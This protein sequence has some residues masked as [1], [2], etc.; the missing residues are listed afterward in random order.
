[1]TYYHPQSQIPNLDKIYERYFTRFFE[2]YSGFFVEVG[3]YDGYSYS[4]TSGLA[5][6]GWK[7]IYIEPVFEYYKK[8]LMRHKDNSVKVINCAI[9]SIEEQTDLYVGDYLTTLDPKYVEIYGEIEWSKKIKFNKQRTNKVRLD[10][11][12]KKYKVKSNF[13]LLVVDVEGFEEDVFSSFSIEYWRPK[14]I[15][16]ELCDVHFS[17]QK[18]NYAITS[19]KNLRQK[20][21]SNNYKQI[22]VDHINTVFVRE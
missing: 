11:I 1:M 16:V 22:F 21:L 3:A 5:D 7:G 15:I 8:C 6:S 4:N 9:G 13:D 19:H 17:F 2:Q 20:I 10:N 12:L 14:M 18:Y